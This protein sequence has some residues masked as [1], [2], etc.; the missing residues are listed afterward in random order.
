M[1]AQQDNTAHVGTLNMRL[2]LTNICA[3]RQV[4]IQLRTVAASLQLSN[5]LKTMCEKQ[6]TLNTERDQLT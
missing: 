2:Y 6:R 3:N 1:Q 4:F 5:S